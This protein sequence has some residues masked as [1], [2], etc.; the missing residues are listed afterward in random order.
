MQ[1]TENTSANEWVNWIEEKTIITKADIAEN[2]L[3]KQ[4]L[5]EEILSTNNS[6]LRGKLSQIFGKI[7]I[8]EIDPITVSK[9]REKLSFEKVN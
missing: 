2:N 5:N 7:N 9:E 6:E 1:G 8:K 3:S 4:E